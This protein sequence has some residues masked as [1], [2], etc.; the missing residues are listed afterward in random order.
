MEVFEA[1][2]GAQRIGQV[3]IY[4]DAGHA[5][6]TDILWVEKCWPNAHVAGRGQAGKR[7]EHCDVFEDD[8]FLGKE[9]E[10]RIGGYILLHEWGH[11]FY[12]LFDEYQNNAACSEDEGAPCQDDKPVP[13]SAMNQSSYAV[14]DK[15]TNEPLANLNPIWLN[16]SVPKTNT[17]QTAHHRVYGQS[18][19]ETLVT[20]PSKDASDI[21][22]YMGRAFYPELIPV[23]PAAD[24]M[25]GI[26]ITAP[27]A[28]EQARSEL[29]IEWKHGSSASSDDNNRSNATEVFM[30]RQL[31]VETSSNITAE[32][33]DA[34][35]NA[36]QSIISA[37]DEY[38]M[39]GLIKFDGY[40]EVVV[41]PVQLNDAANREKL[42]QAVNNLTLG[43]A[44]SALGNALNLALSG[45]AHEDAHWMAYLFASGENNSGIAFEPV[46]RNYAEEGILLMS[47][48]TNAKVNQDLRSLSLETNG[49]YWTIQ[50]LD[51]LSKLIK[52]AEEQASPLVIPTI[53]MGYA[54]VQGQQNFNFYLDEH[55]E[56]VEVLAWYFTLAENQ[57][58]VNLLDPA[59]NPINQE[60]AC[61]KEELD[62]EEVER[63]PN[64]NLPQ[65]NIFMLVP[66]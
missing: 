57:V 47:F 19:W 6:N 60:N 56:Q 53:A 34:V 17:K 18:G 44:Q 10:R 1:S 2:N 32:Q 55:L 46:M 51:R 35:K 21:A 20:D 39:I 38:E 16:F 42:L 22:K 31:V 64:L 52:E 62:A 15:N 24:A 45:F 66:L 8:N 63:Q 12:G 54:E 13:Y 36:L 9:H 5:N 7:V 33:L 3:T 30:V 50:Q 11:F 25:P 48:I 43:N 29:K 4:T 65:M 61:V 14:I 23:A 40:A 41:P 28:T 37:A 49:G 26:F 27:G 58:K 59:K